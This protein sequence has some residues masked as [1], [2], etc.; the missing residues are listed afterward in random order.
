MGWQDR[1][2]AREPRPAG[3]Y[4]GG[5]RVGGLG[6]WFGGLP[7]IT[8]AAKWI[9]IANAVMFVLCALTGGYHGKV[10]NSLAM[11]TDLVLQ[12]EVWRLVTFTYI[13]GS[14]FHIAMNMLG[15]Y[16]L[17]VHLERHWGSKRFFIFYTLSGAVA[18]ALYFIVTLMGWLDPR[19]PLV[20]AS[21][22]V[23]AVLGACAVLFPQIRL[24]V[25]VFPL[26]IRTFVLLFGCIYAFNLLGRGPNAGGD[27]CHL[28]GMAFGVAWAYHGDRWMGM[29]RGRKPRVRAARFERRPGDYP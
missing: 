21:G 28:A 24:V 27:A 19:I 11:R 6:S 3:H 25:F 10:W 15:L 17:G 9:I 4:H 13:H 26:P 22:G 2:Y 23:L 8:R 16:L 29:I 7:P 14:G 18:V 12:G 1:D 5:P 20:G